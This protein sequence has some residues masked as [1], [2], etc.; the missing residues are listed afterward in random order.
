MITISLCMIVKNEEVVLARCLDSIKDIVDEIIIVDTGSTDNTKEIA[1]HYTQNVYDFQWVNDFSLARNYSFSKATKDYQMWLDADDVITEKDQE[2]IRKLKETLDPSYDIVTFKY[3]THF[4]EDNNPILTSTRERLF[5]R[6]NHYLW[7]DPVH[8]YIELTGK[9]YYAND[10]FVTHKK[11]A[12]YT[13][14]NLKIY[15]GLVQTGK[16]LSP[17]NIYYYARELKDHARYLEAIYYFEKFLKEKEGWVE[18]NIASCYNL[19]LCYKAIHDDEKFLSSLIRSF[20]YDSPRAEITCEIAY[21]YMNQ[22]DYDKAIKWFILT[23]HLEV[24]STL[25]FLL[26]DYWGFIPNIE[27]C[28][29]YY[30]LGNI[31]KARFYNEKAAIYKPNSEEVLYNKKFFDSLK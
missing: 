15:E 31:E 11:E 3:H 10:I 22:K 7:K 12:E 25:G 6:K 14:R 8:E 26:N 28:V 9:I 20:E 5:K 13:D 2:K 30:Q 29:C 27:L 1:Y 4:D 19:A 24:P 23:T 16:K 18:D 21:Y 17:R